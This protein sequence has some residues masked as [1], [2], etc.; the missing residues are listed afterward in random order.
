VQRRPRGD[1][2]V[3]CLIDFN[4]S[5][6]RQSIIQLVKR[7]QRPSGESLQAP[8]EINLKQADYLGPFATAILAADYLHALK[9]GRPYTILLPNKPRVNA[10]A[11]FSGLRHLLYGEAAPD[12][13]N[14]QNVTVPITEIEHTNFTDPDAII[15]L[16]NRFATISADQELCLSNA[17]IEG[18]QN[19]EDHS[20]SVVGAVLCARY[21]EGKG[22]IRV[23]I[24]DHGQGI[25]TTLN[26]KYP[27]IAGAQTAIQ[28]TVSGGFSAKTK[29]NNQGAGIRNIWIQI[30]DQ[31]KGEIF[32]L[33]EDA[34][35]YNDKG[36]HLRTESLDARFDGT[37]VF[38]TVPVNERAEK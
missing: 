38:F 33:T 17:I 14:P 6:E 37:G 12:R 31:L 35:G 1:E 7:I 26:R 16:V 2:N 34:I 13:E 27:E 23:A 11:A 21:L 10:F 18:L 8:T 25:W 15:N 3:N 20:G 29:P 32:I 24:V 22:K 30:V 19:V 9:S 28:R 36:G 5:D 4:L